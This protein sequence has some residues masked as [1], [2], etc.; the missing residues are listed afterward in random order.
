MEKRVPALFLD[1][2]MK[3]RVRLVVA[4]HFLYLVSEYSFLVS[5]TKRRAAVDLQRKTLVS[6]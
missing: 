6:V 2:I 4:F 3:Q 5:T 1:D